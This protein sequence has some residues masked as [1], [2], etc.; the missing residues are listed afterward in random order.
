MDTIVYQAHFSRHGASGKRF[1]S[2]EEPVMIISFFTDPRIYE[3][4]IEVRCEDRRRPENN[5]SIPKWE[6]I[7]LDDRSLIVTATE[8][9]CIAWKVQRNDDD[10]SR[11]M[12]D[13]FLFAPGGL[14]DWMD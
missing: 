8:G 5:L 14:W 9:C 6:I 4:I 2:G 13:T 10:K 3:R 12:G 1:F 7:R 11:I